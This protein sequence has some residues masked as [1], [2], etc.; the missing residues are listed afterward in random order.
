LQ[1]LRTADGLLLYVGKFMSQESHSLIRLRRV[2][3][4]AE[5]DM[6]SNRICS[7][8]DCARGVG[9]ARIGVN[10]NVAEIRSARRGRR[11]RRRYFRCLCICLSLIVIV[12]GADHE[13]F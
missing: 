4:G 12:Q 13:S 9:S 8:A 10:A 1:H 6:I 3:A 5:H 11:R 2:S 7:R